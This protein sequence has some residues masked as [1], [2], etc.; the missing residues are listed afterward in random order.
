MEML[1]IIMTLVCVVLLITSMVLLVKNVIG[2]EQHNT[3]FITN[4]IKLENLENKV[5][6]LMKIMYRDYYDP[7]SVYDNGFFRNRGQYVFY[8]VEV[9][10]V[11][12][13]RAPHVSGIHAYDKNHTIYKTE[14]EAK[15]YVSKLMEDKTQEFIKEKNNEYNTN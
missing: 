3:S 8:T 12:P 13:H 4:D 2:E 6:R 10:D 1:Q 5:L 7:E 11:I 14:E 15:S 9:L